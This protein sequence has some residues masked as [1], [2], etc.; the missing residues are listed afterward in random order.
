MQVM[1]CCGRLLCVLVLLQG[2]IRNLARLGF[3]KW[4]FQIN[5]VYC[6]MFR[7]PVN[8]KPHNRF[9]C[10]VPLDADVAHMLLSEQSALMAFWP[11]I[12]IPVMG[13]HIMGHNTGTWEVL[14]RT[15]TKCR[16]SRMCSYLRL[17]TLD[18]GVLSA[19]SA[20]FFDLIF[21]LESFSSGSYSAFLTKRE[22]APLSK[23]AAF[24]LSVS[25]FTLFMHDLMRSWT[26]KNYRLDTT[27]INRQCKNVLRGSMEDRYI[28]IPVWFHVLLD[29]FLV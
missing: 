14:P 25:S 22:A 9:Q 12:L 19:A 4:N 24:F 6:D 7:D 26:T 15:S 8:I 28:P 13:R 10:C 3:N 2:E 21:F 23:R 5:S 1:V 17:K 27:Q 20:A 29:L 11:T 16:G 18:G